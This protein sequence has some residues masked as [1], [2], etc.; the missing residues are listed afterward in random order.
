MVPEFEAAA[1]VLKNS[2]DL[3]E[4]IKTQF[5]WHIIRLEGRT[6]SSV[7]PL[8]TVKPQLLQYLINEK[9]NKAFKNEVEGLKKTYK[10]EMLVPEET[11]SEDTTSEDKK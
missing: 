11:A 6:P 4:P 3:S 5:G 10:V 7:E 9:R 1:F 2:G 8:D